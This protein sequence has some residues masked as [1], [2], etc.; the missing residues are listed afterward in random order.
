MR[1]LQRVRAVRIRNVLR[2]QL[3]AQKLL[4]PMKI[5]RRVDTTALS[6]TTVR[7]ATGTSRKSRRTCGLRGSSGGTSDEGHR[8]SVA[9]LIS[10]RR[11]SMPSRRDQINVRASDEAVAILY[12]LQDH[13]GISQA[14]I[15]EM[16]LRKASRE[17]K[18]EMN[19]LMHQ[20]ANSPAS[21]RQ[22]RAGSR[23]EA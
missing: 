22:R 4:H 8:P 13:W 3:D 12:A 6:A 1:C 21:E 7:C 2:N 14:A 10:E 20:R 23:R 5:G 15:I 11:A 17:E 16:L 9:R 19:S 18:L